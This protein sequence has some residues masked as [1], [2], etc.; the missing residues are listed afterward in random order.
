LRGAALADTHLREGI[1]GLPRRCLERL[2]AADFIV[3]AGD[4]SSMRAVRELRAIGPPVYAVRGNVEAP[5]VRRALPEQLTFEAGGA[6]I[7]LI[8]DAGRKEGRL[9]RL[10]GWFPDAD[11]VV[12]GHSHMP[13][14]ER[15]P[16]FAIFNPGSPTQRRRAPT[17]TMG[18]IMVERGRLDLQVVDLMPGLP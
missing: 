7:S 18:L 3:H 14:I 17:R 6:R 4:H 9:L 15:A 5:E 2:E 16:G 12:F 13:L 11:A 1:G 8:H 10:R